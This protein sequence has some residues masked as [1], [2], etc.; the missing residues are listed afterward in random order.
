MTTFFVKYVIVRKIHQ[1]ECLRD[2]L[3][4]TLV[5]ENG[6]FTSLLLLPDRGEQHLLYLFLFS[7]I[8]SL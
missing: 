2:S 1:F 8:G 4:S 3:G 6:I 7:F 5:N